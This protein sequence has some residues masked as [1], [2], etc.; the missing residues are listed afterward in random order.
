MKEEFRNKKICFLG[1]SIIQNGEFINCLRSYF[2]NNTCQTS[3]LFFN[4]GLGGNRSIMAQALLE[5]E[6]ITLRPDY[7]FVHYGVNDLGIWLYDSDKEETETLLQEREERNR[8]FFKGIENVV[9]TLKEKGIKPVL[10]SPCAVNE[11]LVERNEIQTVKDN[12]E[13]EKLINN[14]FYKKKTFKNINLALRAYNEKLKTY[15]KDENIGY[16]DVFSRMLFL[17]ENSEKLYGADGIHLTEVG[18]Q[19]LAKIILQY[20][21][22][23]NIPEMFPK[24]EWVEQL[25]EIEKTERKIQYVKWAVFHPSLGYDVTE[26]EKNARQKL[27]EKDL[28]VFLKDAIRT[29]L[30]YNGNVEGLRVALWDLMKTRIKTETL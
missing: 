3:P 21:S 19:E 30:Q 1:D 13:K 17:L 8:L 16:V 29:Y 2:Q 9:K 20:L 14:S 26:V 4:R 5:D 10:I 18:Q 15:A 22:C 24:D 27:Q 28:S 11:R 6:V 25:A 12:K 7:C 23:K